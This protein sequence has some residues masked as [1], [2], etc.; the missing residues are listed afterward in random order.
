MR[1]PLEARAQSRS[2]FCPSQEPGV[3]FTPAVGPE[4]VAP[5][6]PGSICD[7]HLNPFGDV[8]PPLQSDPTAAGTARTNTFGDASG[9]QAGVGAG[10]PAEPRR[11][12]H[13]QPNPWSA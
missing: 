6:I 13:R 8:M 12:D 10:L 3:H 2:G 11:D 5:N 1:C 7:D 9:I 4:V